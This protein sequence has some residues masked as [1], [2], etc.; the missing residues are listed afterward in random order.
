M[1]NKQNDNL[2]KELRELLATAEIPDISYYNKERREVFC[3]YPIWGVVKSRGVTERSDIPGKRNRCVFFTDM[4][5][6]KQR[7]MPIDYDYSWNYSQNFKDTKNICYCPFQF[8]MTRPRAR[9]YK[10]VAE[11]L[12]HIEVPEKFMQIKFKDDIEKLSI[13]FDNPYW[14]KFSNAGF[15]DLDSIY[16][17]QQTKPKNIMKA[18]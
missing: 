3:L 4:Q 13:W 5:G 1:K 14:I 7:F 16:N 15:A 10:L 9:K 8:Y 11:W 12:F 18:N 2:I 6:N 17:A